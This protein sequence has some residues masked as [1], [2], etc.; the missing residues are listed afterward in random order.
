MQEISHIEEKRAIFHIVAITLD[1]AVDVLGVGI[2]TLI[3]RDMCLANRS[4]S[5]LVLARLIAGA[6]PPCSST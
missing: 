4:K 2:L 3:I 5:H 6:R 1:A